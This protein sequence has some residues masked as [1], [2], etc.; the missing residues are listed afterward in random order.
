LS[1]V[2]AIELVL[3]GGMLSR[4]LDEGDEGKYIPKKRRGI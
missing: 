3:L 4:H 1:D 2:I